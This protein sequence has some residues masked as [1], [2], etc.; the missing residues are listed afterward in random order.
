[1]LAIFFFLSNQKNIDTAKGCE[2]IGEL[3][4]IVHI[5]ELSHC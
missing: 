1:M 3:I 5:N 2:G 4:G